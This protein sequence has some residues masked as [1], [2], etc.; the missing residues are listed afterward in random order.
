MNSWMAKLNAFHY[1]CS[2]LHVERFQTLMQLIRLICLF[3]NLVHW[4]ATCM[5]GRAVQCPDSAAFIFTIHVLQQGRAGT[6]C[7]VISA[8][9]T[10]LICSS[11]CVPA[12]QGWA[13]ILTPWEA[14]LSPFD[15]T[16]I[17][18]Q[19]ATIIDSICRLRD[20]IHV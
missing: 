2:L 8:L 12:F 16:E 15:I 13:C 6:P 4:S 20:T 7:H 10:L 5:R 18:E 17:D 3:D 1:H 19:I 9:W 11:G 14:I